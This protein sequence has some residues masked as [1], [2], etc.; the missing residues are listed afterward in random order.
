M[1]LKTIFAFALLM[2]SS[3]VAFSQI[4]IGLKGG[5]SSSNIY[6]TEAIDQVLPNFKDMT[7]FNIGA[8]AEIGISDN[9][10]FQPEIGFTKKGFAAKEGLDIELLGVPVPLGVKAVTQIDY[11][12]VP[13]LAKYKFGNEGINAYVLAGPSIGYALDGRVLTKAT[14]LIDFNIA[15]TPINLDAINYQRLEIGGTAGAGFAV[16]TG[17]GQLFM[18]A[19]YNLGFTQLYDIPLVNEKLRN[20]S[21]AINAGFLIPIG[22]SGARP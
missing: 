1:N 18:D 9:F 3:I 22:S 4:S 21:F 19:R 8:V 13:L 15:K 12:D 10:A 20:K 2:T 16:N 6:A 5:F 17:I 14:V 11:I 7:S